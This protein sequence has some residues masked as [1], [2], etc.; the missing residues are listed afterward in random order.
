[1]L[2]PAFFKE[3]HVLSAM[4]KDSPIL[5]GLSGGADSS[6]LLQL[7]CEYRREAGCKIFAAH[8]NHGIRC[9]K[10]GNEAERDELFCREICQ[11][12]GVPLF[13][14]LL[15]IP[16]MS[17]KSGKSLETEARDARYAFFAEIMRENNIKILVTA[18]NADDNLETQIYNLARGCGIDGMV[19]IPEKRRFDK[20][21]G[22]MVIRP[23]L[24]AEKKEILAFCSEHGIAYVTDS[25]NFEDDCTRNAIR[26][27]MIPSLSALFPSL[28][29]SALRL[30]EHAAEDS[31]FI[32]SEARR[33]IQEHNGNISVAELK[34]LHPALQK[35]IIMHM[36]EKRNGTGLESTHISDILS[37]LDSKRNGASISLPKKICARIIDGYLYIEAD[38]KTPLCRHE[39]YDRELY[40]GLNFIENTDFAVLIGDEPCSTPRGY[41]PYAGAKV[42]APRS[43]T[44]H[45]KNRSSGDTVLD[46]GVNKKIKKL[47]CDKKVPLLDRDTLP[48]IYLGNEPIYLP[49]CAVSDSAKVKKDEEH[50]HITIYKKTEEENEQRH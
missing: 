1:M 29:R 27:N 25:T 4:P 46:G 40:H 43:Q 47:M 39:S 11:Q 50:M 14:K 9:E 24:K 7:L 45:A 23:I 13:V 10:Y 36:F 41:A 6:A 15:D 3:P 16:S 31:D 22:G 38:S 49:L 17:E 12:L 35:R 2:L 5:L 18:H 44:L 37:L 21:A 28:K 48:V 30:S 33:I 26:L 32:A 34:K 42:K 20:V 8:L 19:G